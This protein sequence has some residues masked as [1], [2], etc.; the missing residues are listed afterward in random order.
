[1]WLG[2]VKKKKH[3]VFLLKTLIFRPPFF[4]SFDNLS[5]YIDESA[6]KKR[7]NTLDFKLLS[8]DSRHNF[9]SQMKTVKITPTATKT[10]SVE[11]LQN[12]GRGGTVCQPILGSCLTT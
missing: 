12:S 5:F 6:F 11:N 3:H 8:R 2:N 10:S 9:S 7:E 4:C 1:M